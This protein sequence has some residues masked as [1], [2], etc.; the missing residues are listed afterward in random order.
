MQFLSVISEEKRLEIL[1]TIDYEIAQ[2]NWATTLGYYLKKSSI[3]VGIPSAIL[4]IFGDLP[5]KT[6]GLFGIL[7]ALLGYGAGKGL[8]KLGLSDVKKGLEIL[9]NSEPIKKYI[10]NEIKVFHKEILD[11]MKKEKVKGYISTNIPNKPNEYIDDPYW[12][13]RFWI[14]ASRND[15]KSKMFK[16]DTIKIKCDKYT[17]NIEYDEND[18]Y[19]IEYETYVIIE[20]EAY[21]DEFWYGKEGYDPE[22]DGERV[23]CLYFT[24]LKRIKQP[25]LD[26]MKKNGAR[27]EERK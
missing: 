12:T 11:F 15:R 19:K 13:H 27:F 3:W 26:Q 16:T 24:A 21:I 18:I 8:Q 4:T 1:D 17:L 20:D 5:L 23:K 9:F 10:D 6:V 2:E 22:R 25:T 14:D 7:A